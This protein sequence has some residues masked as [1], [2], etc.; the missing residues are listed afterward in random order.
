MTSDPWG[1]EGAEIG[2]RKAA[3]YLERYL[4]IGQMRSGIAATGTCAADTSMPT[5]YSDN[6]W[7]MKSG[8]W[9][10]VTKD[11]G[12]LG[13]WRGWRRRLAGFHGV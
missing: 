3:P 11:F 6:G 9:T 4:D 1:V 7:K 8:R 13:T 12:L 5:A 10:P 2:L